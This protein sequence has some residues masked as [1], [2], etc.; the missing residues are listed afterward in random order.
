MRVVAGTGCAA[1]P[2]RFQVLGHAEC[3]EGAIGLEGEPD[4]E[5]HAPERLEPRDVAPVQ[6]DAPGVRRLDAAQQREEGGLAGAVRPDDA[7]Q[8]ARG[9]REIDRVSRDHAAEALVQADRLHRR[10][11]PGVGQGAS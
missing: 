11:R 7:A 1:A 10:L 3:M 5:A 2:R 9:Q 4:A 8:L 6:Q